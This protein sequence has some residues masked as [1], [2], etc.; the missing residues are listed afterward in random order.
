MKGLEL[1]KEYFWEM[2]YPKFKEK[3][4]EIADRAAYGL[5]GE[6]SECF[7]FDDEFSR[8]HDWGPSFCVWLNDGDF[9]KY[10]RDFNKIYMG[11]PGDFK[12]YPCRNVSAQ[13]GG[14]VGVMRISDFY[15][16]FTGCPTVPDTLGKWRA[17]P[18]KFLAM[19]TNGEVFK[20]ELGEFSKIRQGLK[21]YFPEDLRIKKIAGKAAVMAQSGQY[22]Y[23]RCT[24]RGENVAAFFALAEFMEKTANMVYLLNKK[25]M[26]FYKWAH[27]GLKNMPILP[28]IYDI[29]KEIEAETDKNK[30]FALIEK[31]SGLVIEE[32][33]RQGLTDS[34]SDFLESHCASIISRIQNESLRRIHVMAD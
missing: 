4:G 27:R 7:G 17:I 13:G 30:I 22:N 26:P 10:A 31:I 32:L 6:G 23:P 34:N 19:A 2:G 5:V 20:D 11:L 21:N 24:K 25:Y 29:M 9:E 14:R 18:E 8:D 1:S 3:L 15:M 12:N 33:K 16:K 28:Q